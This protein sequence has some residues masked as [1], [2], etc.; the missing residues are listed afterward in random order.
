MRTFDVLQAWAAGTQCMPC[1]T[2]F[3]AHQLAMCTSNV[4]QARQTGTQR[5][6]CPKAFNADQPAMFTFDVLQARAAGTQCMQCTTAFLADKLAVRTFDVLQAR[7]A[8]TP[9]NLH[10]EVLHQHVD[11]LLVRLLGR[12]GVRD[13][14]YYTSSSNKDAASRPSPRR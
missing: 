5:T 14:A 2:A 1:S 4:L 13:D 9:C 10:G 6:R 12:G 11:G 7:E 3:V 8:G